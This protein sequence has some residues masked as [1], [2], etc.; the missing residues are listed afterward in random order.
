MEERNPFALAECVTEI[1]SE[2][3]RAL[4]LANDAARL[5]EVGG[6]TETPEGAFDRALAD[7]LA[8]G[9]IDFLSPVQGRSQLT[10]LDANARIAEVLEERRSTYVGRESPEAVRAL[11]EIMLVAIVRLRRPEL[12]RSR[13]E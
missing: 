1:T 4:A 13:D 12:R 2:V 9:L 5:A 11:V 3:N 6:T 8:L 10:L 7:S